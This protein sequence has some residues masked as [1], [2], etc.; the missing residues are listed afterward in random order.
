[1]S[2]LDDLRAK[3]RQQKQSPQPQQVTPDIEDIDPFF[4]GEGDT[5]REITQVNTQPRATTPPPAAAGTSVSDDTDILTTDTSGGWLS[6][7]FTRKAKT[8]LQAEWVQAVNRPIIN[9]KIVGMVSP[10]GG[11]GKT[12]I[13]QALASTIA[14]NRSAGGVVGVDGDAQSILVR[15]MKSITGKPQ[16]GRGITTFSQD[17]SL[18]ASAPKVKT[19]LTTNK[20]GYSVLP[21]AGLS[22]DD[23]PQFSDI[24][25]S[26]RVL[27]HHYELLFLDLP[28]A[29]ETEAVTGALHFL[30]GMIYVMATTPDSVY[31]GKQQLEHIALHYPELMEHT[32]VILNHQSDGAV[33]IDLE[34]E[35]EAISRIGKT[36]GTLPVYEVGYDPHMYEG[37][38]MSVDMLKKPAQRD[39]LKIAAALFDTL[40][41]A[42]PPKINDE[43][44]NQYYNH[45]Q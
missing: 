37:G 17:P 13:N 6:R 28:G 27:A 38:G 30:D 3:Y 15:R 33:K 29:R 34:K 10:K 44:F 1:M 35:K 40:D 12:S 11:V 43:L 23:R 14:V 31:L 4:D 21:G 45:Q 41:L 22:G 32:M 9:P 5:E 42:S 24:V 39:F 25:T 2:E 19:F 7:L 26:M 18:L 8:D 16:R 20:E 36:S